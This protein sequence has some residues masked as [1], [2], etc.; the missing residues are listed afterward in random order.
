MGGSTVCALE[1]KVCEKSW[2]LIL[3]AFCVNRD[4]TGTNAKIGN[5]GDVD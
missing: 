2:T 5:Y 3:S 4:T 1:L